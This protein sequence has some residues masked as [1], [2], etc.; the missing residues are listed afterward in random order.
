MKRHRARP[1]DFL[2]ERLFKPLGMNAPRS[3]SSDKA[4]RLRRPGR[5][6][7]AAVKLYDVSA[8]PAMTP[9]C[10][11]VSTASDYLRPRKCCERRP[12]DGKRLLSRKSVELMTSTTRYAHPAQSPMTPGEV[13][14]MTPGYTFGLGFAVRQAAGV[15][16]RAGSREFMWA[17]TREPTSGWTRR[18]NSSAS[19]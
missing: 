4:G 16:A 10:G 15:A 14:L 3:S 7:S 9:R 18:N 13:L 11:A 12:A 17:A 19:T 6:R 2:E 8:Q 1:H 5:I